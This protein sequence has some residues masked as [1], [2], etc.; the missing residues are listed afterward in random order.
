MSV[1]RN[2]N[3][4]SLSRSRLSQFKRHKQMADN[5]NYPES[6]PILRNIF[7]I[8]KLL[9]HMTNHLREMLD[10]LNVTL[11][12]VVRE[13]PDTT[14]SATTF[15]CTLNFVLGKLYMMDELVNYTLQKFPSYKADNAQVYN[16]LAKAI[17]GINDMI[18]IV[19]HQHWRDGKLACLDLVTHN[20]GLTRW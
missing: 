15:A 9:D 18:S 19:R 16:L 17:S 13:G 4:A 6:F 2:F 10:V 1:G 12:Y 20:M 5:Q 3:D 7:T 11:Y 14:C 8:I